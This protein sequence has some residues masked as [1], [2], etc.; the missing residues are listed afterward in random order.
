MKILS[1]EFLEAATERALKTAGQFG[2]AAIGT[3]AWTDIEQIAPAGAV[4]GYA[5]LFGM[6]SSYLTSL[7]SAGIGNPGPSLANEAVIPAGLDLETGV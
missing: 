2:A 5:L 3:V 7:A 1:M 6:V 4:I